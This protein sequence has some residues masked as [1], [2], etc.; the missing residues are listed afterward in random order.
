MDKKPD[1]K[2]I[3]EEVNA[4][5]ESDEYRY[6]N[7]CDDYGGDEFSIDVPPPTISGDLHMG[8]VF[9]YCHIDFI[10]RFQRMMGNSL[11]F[12]IGFDVT[13]EPT[14][15]LI[16]DSTK[17]NKDIIIEEYIEK[18]KALF[19]RLG[20]SSDW[21]GSYLTNERY[22]VNKGEEVLSILKRQ[23]VLYY[24]EIPKE[25]DAK[26]SHG[27]F[28]KI[29]D[30][31]E[32]LKELVNQINWHPE[33]MKVRLLNWIDD[34][35]WDWNISRERDFGVAM[36]TAYQKGNNRLVYDTWF[37]SSLT[38][39]PTGRG[40]HDLRCQGHDIIRT[41]AFYT[42]VQALHHPRKELP[43]R[44]IM[45]SGWCIDKDGEKMSKS[46]GNGMNPDQVL[47]KYGTDVVRYWAAST[48]LGED[49]VFSEKIL[50]EGSALVTKLWN[51]ARFLNAQHPKSLN[52]SAKKM[53]E[54]GDEHADDTST[55]ESHMFFKIVSIADEYQCEIGGCNYY[56]AFQLIKEFFYKDY[57]NNY[58]ELF[59][60]CAY[61]KSE[62]FT[63]KQCFFSRIALMGSFNIILKLFAPFLPYVTQK[64]NDDLCL[65]RKV[66]IH[67]VA[68]FDEVCSLRYSV[69]FAQDGYNQPKIGIKILEAC[70]KF[71][72]KHNMSMKSPI[73]NV[74]LFYL[75]GT[76]FPGVDVIKND[77]LCTIH[78]KDIK[79][80]WVSEFN[81]PSDTV[82]HFEVCGDDYQ[83][84][85]TIEG[86]PDVEDEAE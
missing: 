22:F 39:L 18:Y 17:A 62:L 28:V 55:F 75:E 65:E 29:V 19:K 83:V 21:G 70:R 81:D 33:H 24:A 43:W 37:L 40:L 79:H 6:A 31:K 47:N 7:E 46:E 8:H 42:I 4:E 53:N 80:A 23:G 16:K 58:L 26:E 27:W 13:G 44:N 60:T 82:F 52:L 64:I 77:L 2:K 41:W 71:K 56:R 11:R 20:I 86:E 63:K 78:A 1:F 59:K 15:K 32:E 25:I 74:N 45:I 3:E 76:K 85:F 12:S 38:A 14:E 48:P 30:K 9:S 54:I 36:P 84:S 34:L 66:P 73:T 67:R 61:G 35:K 72:S 69:K 10:A 50:K 51:V 68:S 57:C 49:T 5:W